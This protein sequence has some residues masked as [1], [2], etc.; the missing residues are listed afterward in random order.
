MCPNDH[1]GSDE[2][3][4]ITR[5]ADEAFLNELA[6]RLNEHPMI[7]LE[8]WANGRGGE[9]WHLV[10][11]AESLDQFARLQSGV[12]IA[13]V[14]DMD[15]DWCPRRDLVDRVRRRY[16]A[17]EPVVVFN[18]PLADTLLESAVFLSGIDSAGGADLPDCG[19]LGWFPYPDFEECRAISGPIDSVWNTDLQLIW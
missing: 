2:T 3:A 18:R 14:P 4:V 19:E 13:A 7:V 11:R 8:R 17:D 15:M 12:L 6:D 9:N 5:R 1:A 16:A 10:A